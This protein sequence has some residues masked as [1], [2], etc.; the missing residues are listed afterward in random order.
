MDARGLLKRLLTCNRAQLDTVVALLG[1]NTAFLPGANEPVATRATGILDLL[2]QRGERG[3]KQLDEALDEVLGE[4]EAQAEP[5]AENK[6]QIEQAQVIL[7]LSANPL[8]TNSLALKDEQRA[9][10]RELGANGR[11]ASYRVEVVRAVSA[12]ELSELLL[13]HRPR[14]VHFSG[15]GSPKGNI[16]LEGDRQE[17]KEVT[18]QSLA[19]L[20]SIIDG[21]Q[22]VV[23]NACYSALQAEALAK[24]VPHVIGMVHEIG[25]DASLR[26]SEGFYRGLAFG[27]D[28]DKA[29]GLGC[30]QIDLAGLPDTLIPHFLKNGVESSRGAAAN[31]P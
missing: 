13:R 21:T 7:L 16:Y 5:A 6:Q 14:I 25:D 12:T 15:H 20:F 18:P 2:R 30:A 29:F 24:R 31:R 28:F 9:I 22:A 11:T 26:F 8:G 4:P 17:S 27:L 3:L 1:L 19:A 10:E 23:L